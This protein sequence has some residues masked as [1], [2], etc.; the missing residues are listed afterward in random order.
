MV[1]VLRLIGLDAPDVRH[2]AL[3]RVVS[4]VAWGQSEKWK[5][6]NLELDKQV[7]Q[8]ESDLAALRKVSGVEDI[9]GAANR[10]VTH[11]A[12][13]APSVAAAGHAGQGC[14]HSRRAQTGSD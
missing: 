2:V 13:I 4:G 11:I 14:R 3:A 7:T 1:L 10:A 9:P 8:L 12:R 5:E 6:S